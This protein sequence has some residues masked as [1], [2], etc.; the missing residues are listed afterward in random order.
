[1]IG[2][3]IGV[4]TFL[5]IGIFHPV[6][7]KGEYHFGVQKPCYFFIAL[8]IISTVL[9]FYIPNLIASIILG[10]LACCAFWS[11]KEMKEQEERVLKGWFPENPKRSA[12]YEIKRVEFFKTHPEFKAMYEAKNKA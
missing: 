3:L 10:V 8:G 4:I 12:Y 7:I 1:M 5:M 11:I 2:L 6:V 9:A